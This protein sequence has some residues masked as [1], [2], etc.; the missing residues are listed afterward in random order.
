MAVDYGKTA[1]EVLRLIG[2]KANIKLVTHCIT[3][4]RFELKDN[5]IAHSNKDQIAAVD[6]VLKVVESGGQFQVVIGPN[7]EQVYDLVLQKTGLEG[8]GE[9]AADSADDEAADG[10]SNGKKQNPIDLLMGTISGVLAPTLGV[11]AAAGIVKGLISLT[12]TLG[13]VSETS[14]EYM[15]LYAIGD[16]FYYFLP[17]ILGFTAAR[18]FKSNEIIGAAIGASLVYPAM[19]NIATTLQVSGT[20]FEGTNFAMSYYNTFFGIPIIL[21]GSGYISSVI[22][23]ILAV[24]FAAKLEKALKKSLPAALR[25]ILTPL[26]TLV[27]GVIATYLVIG[28]VSTVLTGLI[29]TFIQF[30]FGIPVLGGII[31]GAL[32]GGGFG[33]LVMFGLHWAL[34]ALG[35][36]TIASTGFDYMLACGSIGPMIGI[37]QGLAIV[38]AASRAKNSKVLDLA[39]PGTISQICG[40]G[41]PLMYSVLIPLKKE[42]YLNIAAGGLGGAVIGL[43]GTKIY[44]FGGSGLFS[45]PNFVSPTS[46]LT[47][48]VKYSIGVAVGCIFVFVAQLVMYDDNRAKQALK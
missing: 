39:I 32:I 9:V 12:L 36:A 46:G 41:E 33:V 13:W 11:L 45:F 15:L 40:V 19:V 44:M 24:Y 17:I 27:V 14:G 47:D 6:G 1:D 38:I 3:R 28:P 25:G 48:I 10:S 16:A 37:A 35:L 2:G 20:L 29:S 4:L 21:P 8:G 22:P 7:V 34:I 42:L 43:L 18:K 5:G 23:I 31:G 26:I 30:L